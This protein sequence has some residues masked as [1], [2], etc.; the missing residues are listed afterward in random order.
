MHPE[1]VP[2]RRIFV[3][4][5]FNDWSPTQPAHELHYAEDGLWEARI[6]LERGGHAFKFAVDG[7][8]DL[9]WGDDASPT[10]IPPMEGRLQPEGANILINIPLPGLYL[11]RINLQTDTWEVLPRQVGVGP[12][13]SLLVRQNVSWLS[14]F[15]S[16]LSTHGPQ[17]AAE[18]FW[19]TRLEPGEFNGQLPLA[20]GEDVVF[21]AWGLGLAP[22]SVAGTFNDWSPAAHVMTPVPE[23]PLQYLQVKLSRKNRHEYKYVQEGRWFR[24]PHN[25]LVAWDGVDRAAMGD[26]NSVLPA[27]PARKVAHLVWIK[28]FYSL[29][30]N[31]HRDLYV[32]LPPGYQHNRERYP[33]LYANDGRECITRSQLDTMARIAMDTGAS[34]PVIMVFIDLPRPDARR[35]EYI[36]HEGRSRYLRFLSKELVPFVDAHFSTR[37]EP[38]ARGIMGPTWGGFNAYFAAWHHPDVFGKAAAQGGSFHVNDYEMVRI[39]R[40]GEYKP[41]T[42]YLDSSRPVDGQGR[43]DNHAQSVSMAQALQDRGYRYL[44]YETEG[45]P[46]D[47]SSWR[48]RFQHAL[49]FLWPPR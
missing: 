2:P 18:T 36:E 30:L 1:I 14:E 10:V 47:W 3:A 33:V 46:H 6:A 45:E 7:N 49:S 11:F 38:Q 4:A 16:S 29:F 19:R 35:Y 22:V 17:A 48:G 9:N 23:T 43:S 12:V 5:T 32:L 39:I 20:N 44:H 34:E 41:V 37:P 40:D 15:L 21:V 25:A 31:N 8:W 24:D 28:R 13:G 42:F 27:V 26:F